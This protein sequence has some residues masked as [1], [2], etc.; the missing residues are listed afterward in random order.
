M[1]SIQRKQRE[2]LGEPAFEART[3][4]FCRYQV[5]EF[6]ADLDD[7]ELLFRVRHC[8]A[9]ARSYGLTWESSISI[10]V[11]HMMS[12][13]PEFDKHPSIQKTLRD[14]TIDVED[15]MTAMLGTVKEEEWD[16]AVAIG[17]PKAYWAKLDTKEAKE[18]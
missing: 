4:A 13:N 16:E 2:K 14:E 11:A 15:R 7:R 12:I 1:L 3:V 6:V 8:I 17:D 9:K 10:F 5:G 18:T